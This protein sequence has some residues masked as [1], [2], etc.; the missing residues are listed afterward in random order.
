MGRSLKLAEAS[1]SD[2]DNALQQ[3]FDGNKSKL[4]DSLE[5]SRT[6]I[7]NFFSHKPVDTAKFRK[8]CQALRL[9]PDKVAEKPK[10]D[11]IGPTKK[12]NYEIDELV[13]QVRSPCCDKILREHS[14]IR[15]LTREEIEVDQLYVDVWVLERLSADVYI[16][17]PRLLQYFDAQEDR[18]CLGH[19]V[20]RKDGT[21]VAKESNRLLVLGKPGAGKTTFLKHLAVNCCKGEFYGDLIPVFL[22][23]RSIQTDSFNVL[24]Q[25]QQTFELS[26]QRLTETLLRSGKALIL[27]DGLDEVPSQWRR[28]VQNQ[29]Q[30][31]ARKYHQN[32][33]ILTCRTQI[34]ESLPERFE[35]VEVADFN[36]EQVQQFVENWFSAQKS[37]QG[38]EQAQHLLEQLE[39]NQPIRE[40]AVTPILLSL[41]CRFFGDMGELPTQRSQLY[42]RGLNQLL[43]EWDRGR[44]IQRE[45]GNEV[46]R[47]LKVS[48]KEKLL[49]VIAA[50]KFEQADNFVLFDQSEVSRWISEHLELT[51]D[52]GE[53]VLEAIEAQHGLL[54]E[55]ANEI[56]SFSHLAFQ[57]YFTAYYYVQTENLS[58]LVNH[59]MDSRWRRVFFLAIEMLQFTEHLLKLMKQHIDQA[60]AKDAKLQQ[61]LSWIQEKA[62]SA[63]ATYKPAIRAFY[64]DLSLDR[65]FDLNLD[66][67]IFRVLNLELGVFINRALSLNLDPNF[68]LDYSLDLDLGL[69]I[70]LS[71]LSPLYLSHNL[72]DSKLEQKLQELRDQLREGRSQDFQQW[73]QA[74]GTTW[75]TKLRAIMIE[76]R[77]IG[78]DWK[79]S[80]EQK[81]L[82]QRYY[83]ANKFL[84]ECLKISYPDAHHPVRQ[85]IES[86]LLLPISAIEQP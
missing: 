54:I 5:M 78:H 64:L 85:E 82:L 68:Y 86:T 18:L 73:L 45:V 4:A 23:L 75:T 49:S 53:A 38:A 83:E 71:H 6:T 7:T 31:F 66:L 56:W 62:E 20:E 34:I 15:L 9:N 72:N 58:T 80:D 59:V 84:V 17:I 42:R 69:C 37:D 35:C 52:D 24:H 28:E 29:I 81:Q 40:L 13:R 2:V 47:Q 11:H 16:T 70:L 67:S 10:A 46:Y 36:P 21:W 50:H 8:I 41:T 65:A 14:K 60:V 25:I 48:Q 3:R 39:Y 12:S 57:E 51:P 27:L 43:K 19:Q 44:D 55:R 63:S 26:D 30:N 1:W 74:H 76:H 33:F 61:C 32:R 77:N 79:F 22:E